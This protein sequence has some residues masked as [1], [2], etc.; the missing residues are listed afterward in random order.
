MKKESKKNY[1]TSY[2]AMP[3]GQYVELVKVIQSG[4]TGTMKD[5]VSIAAIMTGSEVQN[6]MT[7]D[8]NEVVDVYAA[9][10]DLLK[11]LP[12]DVDY[13]VITLNGVEYKAQEVEEFTTRQFTDFDTLAS[14]ADDE[15]IPLLLG[16]IYVQDNGKNYIDDVKDFAEQALQMPTDIALTA[17]RSFSMR[18]LKYAYSML[19]SS[20]QAKKMMEGSPEMKI[21]ME[22]IKN[23]LDGVGN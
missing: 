13:K 19:D 2:S 16:L 17:V 10:I 4:M 14:K 20:T 8:V 3:L 23:L 11:Q 21:Q 18:L 22:K 12:E 9:A 5:M 15:N 7:W 1:P 6:V